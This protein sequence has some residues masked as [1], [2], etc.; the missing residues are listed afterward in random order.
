MPSKHRSRLLQLPLELRLEIY[1]LLFIPLIAQT[2][3]NGY[4][5]PPTAVASTTSQ[6]LSV[7]L[8][9]RQIHTEAHR[10]AFSRHTFLFTRSL[11]DFP[12]H[13]LPSSY[14]H[15][16]IT[17]L[18]IPAYRPPSICPTPYP[19]RCHS[20]K[21]TCSLV[22]RFRS[23]KRIMLVTDAAGLEGVRRHMRGRKAHV[24]Y[25]TRK[26]RRLSDERFVP[27]Y[28][29]RCLDG[30]GSPGSGWK[31]SLS[32]ASGEGMVRSAEVVLC[33]LEEGG[34]KEGREGKRVCTRV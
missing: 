12:L 24:D 26:A 32:V 23:L 29:L 28:D 6:T 22:R 9:C 18:L 33:V 7:L 1:E 27:N 10:L 17:S 14:P 31:W 8:A 16:L 15:A 11:V 20:F 5:V 4:T 21:E 25:R 30:G 13:A 2:P 34:E 19:S 3:A